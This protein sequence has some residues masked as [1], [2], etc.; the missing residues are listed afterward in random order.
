[1][2]QALGTYERKATVTHFV[3][4]TQTGSRLPEKMIVHRSQSPYALKW[5]AAGW[6]V[7]SDGPSEE[8]AFVLVLGTARSVGE[9]G[10]CDPAPDRR[11]E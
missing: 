8:A 4:G 3:R 2:H 10:R 1:M 6:P 9:H 5:R 7:D 11:R